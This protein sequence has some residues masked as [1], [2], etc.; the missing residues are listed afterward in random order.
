[1]TSTPQTQPQLRIAISGAC[2]RMGSAVGRLAAADPD[3]RIA[4]P[5]E[6]RGHPRLGQDYGS[7]L[8]REPLGIS[9]VATLEVAADALID[10]SDPAG[11]LDRLAECERRKVP[12]VIGTTGLGGEAAARLDKAAKAIPILAASNL[13][14]GMNLVFQIVEE[15]ARKLGREYDIEI[16]ETHH[17]HKADAPSGT[18]LTLGEAAAR[19]RGL[20]PDRAFRHGRRGQV[21]KR[22]D[23]EIGLH[24]VRGGDI[25]GEHVVSFLSEGETVEIAHRARSREIFA[26]GAL[27][28]ARALRSRKPGLYSFKDLL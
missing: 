27:H 28:A 13:S 22:G 1:V 21:G 2:G 3:F 23:E 18:A 14:L 10:F 6:R 25:V 26:R 4:A 16:V 20:D 19:G 17:R 24:A 12:I 11:A 15:V 7:V 9:V 8:G 5:L